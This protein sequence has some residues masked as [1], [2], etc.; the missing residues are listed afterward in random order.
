[1]AAG[2]APVALLEAVQRMAA[3]WVGRAVGVAQLRGGRAWREGA[4]RAAGLCRSGGRG[5]TEFVNG[6]REASQATGKGDR[7]PWKLGDGRGSVLGGNKDNPREDQMFRSSCSA[8]SSL[9]LLDA[10]VAS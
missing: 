4:A 7:S 9:A 6:E 5:R 10:W 1:M 8:L 3:A 2:Q